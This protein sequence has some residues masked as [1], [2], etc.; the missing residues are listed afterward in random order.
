MDITVKEFVE[1]TSG[2]GE[3]EIWEK[4][5]QTEIVIMIFSSEKI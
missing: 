5:N 3:Y 1:N 4:N 2:V